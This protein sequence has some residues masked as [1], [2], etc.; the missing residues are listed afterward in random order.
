VFLSDKISNWIEIPTTKKLP[1]GLS[2]YGFTSTTRGTL[3]LYGG[4]TNT[5][6]I[7]R[8]N[9]NLSLHS[10]FWYWDLND[11]LPDFTLV[12]LNNGYGGISRIVLLEGETICILNNNM[13][14]QMMIVDLEKMLFYEII[15]DSSSKIAT[16][17]AYGVVALNSFSVVIIGGSE[18]VNGV[19]N[20]IGDQ[21]I[22]GLHILSE[23]MQ[24]Q[25]NYSLHFLGIL[26]IIPASN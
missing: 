6:N 24:L 12:N 3:V 21:T 17:T 22:F 4:I 11:A 5:G 1:K 15:N 13:T 7:K 9:Q 2:N 18:H 26:A 16:R 25:S 19:L 14:N 8:M 10:D 20:T 23:N